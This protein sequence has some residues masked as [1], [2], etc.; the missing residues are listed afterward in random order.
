MGGNGLHLFF[1]HPARMVLFCPF[2]SCFIFTPSDAPC[3]DLSPHLFPHF[4]LILE[5]LLLSTKAILKQLKSEGTIRVV[6]MTVNLN[7]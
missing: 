5:N 1:D 6:V 3:Y 7:F 2:A 4:L